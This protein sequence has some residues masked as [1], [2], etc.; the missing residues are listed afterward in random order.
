MLL[1]AGHN[2]IQVPQRLRATERST[3]SEFV[4][5]SQP[6]LSAKAWSCVAPRCSFAIIEHVA[7]AYLYQFLHV[8]MR[9]RINPRVFTTHSQRGTPAPPEPCIAHKWTY[10]KV[11]ER[12]NHNYAPDV[13]CP[14]RAHVLSSDSN[15]ASARPHVHT[16]TCHKHKPRLLRSD[17][18]T[19]LL[20][21]MRACTRATTSKHHTGRR[22]VEQSNA[23]AHVCVDFRAT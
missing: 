19:R 20:R 14:M 2:H 15:Y 13:N 22:A 8:H 10:S 9:A 21:H 5:R 4:C 3:D 11:S 23:Q 1:A 18:S 16:H 7:P 6:H 12:T 17:L